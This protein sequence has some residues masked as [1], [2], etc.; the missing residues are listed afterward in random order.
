MMPA[1]PQAASG[2][3][4]DSIVVGYGFA[5]AP[6]RSRCSM[7]EAS[8]CR[9][10]LRR[11]RARSRVATLLEDL[12]IAGGVLAERLGRSRADIV[13][14]IRLLDLP[15]EAIELIDA[16][17]LSKRHG[18][19]LLTELDHRVFY[20]EHLNDP[21]ARR[22]PTDNEVSGVSVET[23]FGDSAA[24]KCRT[25]PLRSSA[26][27]YFLGREG[28]LTGRPGDE[29]MST[30]KSNRSGSATIWPRDSSWSSRALV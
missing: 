3:T 28:H 9:V 16:G 5:G 17:E 18:K 27:P 2:L 6:P 4:P 13:N 21:P 7:C 10:A 26:E 11:P 20:V 15:E 1:F 30:A 8:A 25:P 23:A 24:A 12:P 22:P 14:T 29:R 19:A